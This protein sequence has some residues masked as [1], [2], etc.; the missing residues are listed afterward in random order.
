[1]S[2]LEVLLSIHIFGDYVELISKFNFTV[3]SI[4]HIAVSILYLLKNF[5]SS[6]MSVLKNVSYILEKNMYSILFWSI[7]VYKCQL[8]TVGHYKYSWVFSRF[9]CLYLFLLV[10]PIIERRVLR[11][12]ITIVGCNNCRLI[13]FSLHFY[14]IL[15]HYFEVLL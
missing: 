5:T 7:V 2:Y 1:M 10:L 8:D 9:L 13:Y 3:V 6:N 14:Q 11:Y 15:L 4:I 12:P